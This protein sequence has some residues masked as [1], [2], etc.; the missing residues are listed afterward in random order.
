MKQLIKVGDL[1]RHKLW[2]NEYRYGVVVDD[3]RLRTIESFKI[4]WTPLKSYPVVFND[5]EVYYE[6]VNKKFLEFVS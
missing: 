4:A 2:D 1:V 6:F 5:S 3:S